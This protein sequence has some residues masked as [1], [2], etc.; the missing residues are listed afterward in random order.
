MDFD[1]LTRISN[2]PTRVISAVL[3]NI[4]SAFTA[5][6]GS[7]NSTDH[8]F[9]YIVDLIT[10]VNYGF[11]SRL[12]DVEAGQYRV[13]ARNI[14]DLSKTMSDDDWYGV[15]AEPSGT[16]LRFI[17]SEESLDRYSIR[18][19]EVNGN[20]NN[21]YRKLVIPPDTQ[22]DVAGIPFLLENP[23]EIRV[24][25]HGGYEVV[26]DSTR[27]STLKPLATNTPDIVYLDI[28]RRRYMAITIPVRQLA[29]DAHVN[30]SA[31]PNTG[32]KESIQYEDSL[33]AVRAFIT[34]D[35]SNTRSE[36]AVIFN[37]KIYDPNQVTLVIDLKDENTFEATIP[38]V[39]MQNGMITAARVTILVYTTK[40][41]YYR[42]FSTLQ[43]QYFKAQYFDYANAGGALNEFEKPF[44]KINDVLIDS[45]API[46]GG[47][48]A[49][50]FEELKNMLIYGHRQRQIPVSNSDIS[51]FLQRAGYSSV[52]S[53]DMVTNRLYRVT[54]DLPVQNNKLYQ[55]SSVVRFNSAIGTNVGSMLTSL[56]ELIGS[57]WGIDNGRRVTLL[58]RAAFD[59]TKQ[60]PYLVSKQE[61][62]TLMN[63][64][65]QNKIN[66]LSTKTMAYNP[67]AYVFDT[68]K[69]RATVRI[70]RLSIP[71]IKYQTFRFEN[72]TLGLQ[73]GIDVINMEATKEHY[74]ITVQTKS[75]DAYKELDDAL[76]NLQLSFI[77]AGSTTPVTMKAQ[78]L[79]KTQDGER[80]FMFTLPTRFDVDDSDQIDFSGF[81]QFGRPQD[82]VYI[83]LSTTAN[84]IFTYAGDGLQLLSSSDMKIDQTLF[85]QTNVAIIETEYAVEFG[86]RLSSLYTRIR[87]MVGEGIYEK[88][89]DNVPETY[90]QD[91]YEYEDVKDPTTGITIRQLK[92][93]DG[94]PV[95]KHNRGE[96]VYTEA[97]EPVWRFL[98]GQTVYNSNNEPIELAPR[99]MKYYWDFIGFD[100][101]YLISQDQYDTDYMNTVEDFFVDQVVAQ[102]DDYNK[103]TLDE[104]T[105]VFKPRSTMGFTKVVINEA[106]ERMLKNDLSFTVTYMLT[107]EGLRNQ[108]LKDNL[109]TMTH[110][111]INNIL[112]KD[113]V[114]R[115]DII[116][117]LKELAGNEVI[118][119]RLTALA[120]TTDIDAITNIDS[121][122]GFSVRK[123]VEQTADKFLTIKE[124]IDVQFKRHLNDQ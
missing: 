20:L 121:T 62:D 98:K 122:N 49:T 94:V 53:I 11:I 42:D 123:V 95:I 116:K 6:G 77:S 35:G 44:S 1:E 40:G 101:N 16:S 12:G 8:P 28:D 15:Y 26:Y 25:D 9:P 91:E 88:Y 90:K 46:T 78:L 48:A 102:L 47:R 18:Y 43:N 52:K 104:T 124:D 21:T 59:I 109:V 14:G 45:I 107:K 74:T 32:F 34:P 119:V 24:M 58:Q 51:Q 118:D 114:A 80:R 61:F 97:G 110:T 30:K 54:K 86:R 55:D 85:D 96:Q 112:L 75:S 93:V 87:P 60:T 72:A 113:T 89:E 23:V 36:M 117:V 19:N 13:H 120:G 2:N 83:D 73:V 56:E 29:I 31:N 71:S 70:Y 65:N 69:N 99:K 41:E 66:T 79:G 103:I 115:S 63:S 27:Q 10:G 84:F 82:K 106:I 108:N 22:F 76:V 33:Y 100:F 57:G 5:G 67:F 105:L 81:S 4:E 37:N 64:S 92:L 17:I 50:P 38:P 39:Y 111:Q 7:L 68:T 3:N